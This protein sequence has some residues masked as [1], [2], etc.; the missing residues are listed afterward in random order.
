MKNTVTILDGAMGTMLQKTGLDLG[1][2][3]EALNITNPEAIIEIQRQYVQAGAEILY[4]NTF[5][6]NRRKAAGSGYTCRELI[7][8]GIQ[9]ARKAAE[10]TDVKIALSCGPLGALL[11]PNG[12]MKMEEAYSIFRESMEAGRDAGADLIVIETVTD[13]LEMKAAL[14][15]AKECCSLPVYCTMSFETNGRTFTGVS[16]PAMAATLE[17]LGADAIGINC[18]LGPLEIL[19]LAKELL[20]STSLPVII[21]PNA[22][23][24][25][26]NSN[27]YDIG[28]Q[29]FAEAMGAFVQA[30][31]SIIGG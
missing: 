8:A 15:A 9:N 31:V 13:L 25:N 10:G 16:I 6:A 7:F 2:L 17:G 3:P 18:S 28:P 19:P 23:L 21:K 20:S 12:D 11:E 14:L 22:G 24:P 5:G 1:K 29:E 30:G 27:E 26:L 4:A